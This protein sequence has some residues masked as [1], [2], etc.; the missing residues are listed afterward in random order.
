MTI[1]LTPDGIR[2][3]LN[4]ATDYVD[5]L[6]NSLVK[7]QDELDAQQTQINTLSQDNEQLRNSLIDATATVLQFGNELKRLKKV[8]DIID[9]GSTYIGTPYKF[10]GEWLADKMF[11]CS[12]FV[13]YI[14]KSGGV[15]L[16]RTS[17]KQSEI[18][19]NVDGVANAK[20]GDLFFFD[21]SA[22]RPTPNGIDH[23]AVYLG[24]NRL[25]QANTSKGVNCGDF[26]AFYQSKLVK[27]KR[28]IN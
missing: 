22:T 12:S 1:N 7:T 19:T 4:E 27:I 26:T 8:D 23:V 9:Y 28:V 24:N 11:D 25:L 17:Y 5:M 2:E 21:L 20:R 14:Y 18:G 16:P 6:H 10:G 15:T 13:Q 3:A